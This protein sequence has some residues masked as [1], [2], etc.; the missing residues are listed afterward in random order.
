MKLALEFA[1]YCIFSGAV[2]VAGAIATIIGV[3]WL[4]GGL[5]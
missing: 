4:T 3:A 2:I 1:T 5:Q